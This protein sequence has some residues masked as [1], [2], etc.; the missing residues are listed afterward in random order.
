MAKKDTGRIAPEKASRIRNVAQASA[1]VKAAPVAGLTLNYA[2]AMASAKDHFG[3]GLQMLTA[4]V[5]MRD[6]TPPQLAGVMEYASD[7]LDA[8]EEAK[9]LV[10]GRVLAVAL[11]D[12]VVTTDKGSRRLDLGN[13]KYVPVIPQ[14][15]GTDPAKFEQGLRQKG[16]PVQKYMDAVISYKLKAELASQDMA[17]ADG[18][19]TPDE[20]KAMDYELK[21]RVDRVKEAK[22]ND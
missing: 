14:K 10:R 16:A 12:G 1:L 17:I 8:V 20:V 4:A 21:W 6:L 9:K 11:A 13:G 15:T 19:F 5:A 3:K 7:T 22:S 18:V 2:D